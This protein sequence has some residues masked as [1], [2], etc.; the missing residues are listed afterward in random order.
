M[1]LID[2]HNANIPRVKMAALKCHILLALLILSNYAGNSFTFKDLTHM[3]HKGTF[4]LESGYHS[5]MVEN[6]L[7]VCLKT[8]SCRRYYK[9][10]I[11]NICGYYHV[12]SSLCLLHDITEK[13]KFSLTPTGK[14]FL[15][16]CC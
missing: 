16:L 5:E 14:F 8:L 12:V 2:K 1:S 4:H 11:T 13:I 10:T 7:K 15:I 3:Q 6:I 9:Y